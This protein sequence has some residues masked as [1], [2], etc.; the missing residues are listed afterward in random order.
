MTRR[1]AS[2]RLQP[3][4]GD[5]RNYSETDSWSAPAVQARYRQYCDVVSGE[6]SPSRSSATS[7]VNEGL[8][9]YDKPVQQAKRV[10][11]GSRTDLWMTLCLPWIFRR[12][13][14][15]NSLV[16]FTRRS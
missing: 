1:L 7:G 12:Y 8:R 5:I 16:C 3:Y 11:V 14:D 6:M 13:R 15:V 2:P 4:E 10:P 9:V